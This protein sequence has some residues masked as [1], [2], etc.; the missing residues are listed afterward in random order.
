MKLLVIGDPEILKTIQGI[1]I[2]LVCLAEPEKSYSIK[3]TYKFHRFVHF[4]DTIRE[5]FHALDCG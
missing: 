5:L 3:L 4:S 1:T 2:S